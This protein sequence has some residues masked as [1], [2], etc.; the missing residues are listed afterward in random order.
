MMYCPR[1][2]VRLGDGSTECPLC[3]HDLRG[4]AIDDDPGPGKSRS[5]E[6]IQDAFGSVPERLMVWEAVTVTGALAAIIV[7]AVDFLDSG[8]PTWSL[9]P[10]SSLAFAWILASAAIFFRRHPVPS[11][12]AAGL[13]APL[14]LA[15]LDA[16]D[17]KMTWALPV[18]I[19]IA[20]VTELSVMAT[21]FA[22]SRTRRA[23]T[24]VIAY[25]LFAVS[26]ACMG[27]E[28]TLDLHAGGPPRLYWS[29]V[30]TIAL[31]PIA[32][33]FLYLHHRFMKRTNLRKLL[34]F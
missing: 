12:T 34:R 9:Y 13:S 24:N 1:C 3:R 23:G 31:V 18:G 32:V 19:P 17:G 30:T 15:A 14:F 21:Y 11:V 2:G 25:G 26:A 29:A 8:R 10:V 27:I 5:V 16:I 4:P 33:L 28:F 6:E 20:L 22:V 7:G